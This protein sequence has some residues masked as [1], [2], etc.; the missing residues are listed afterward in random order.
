MIQLVR[1]FEQNTRVAVC[2]V[3]EFG[4]IGLPVSIVEHEPAFG[5]YFAGVVFVDRARVR[6]GTC[7]HRAIYESAIDPNG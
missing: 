4:F 3:L 5:E 2:S 7:F 1:I 6:P